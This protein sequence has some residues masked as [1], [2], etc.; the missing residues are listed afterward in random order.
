MQY[1]QCVIELLELHS[2]DTDKELIIWNWIYK[3]QTFH[4]H[5]KYIFY[6]YFE[7]KFWKWCNIFLT[8]DV[9]RNISVLDCL[10]ITVTKTRNINFAPIEI[11]VPEKCSFCYY[12]IA[13]QGNSHIYALYSRIKLFLLGLNWINLRFTFFFGKKWHNVVFSLVLLIR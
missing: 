1:E 13:I 10:Y 7:V 12:I 6:L 8:S 11:L 5:Q 4:F 2:G 3:S 9:F